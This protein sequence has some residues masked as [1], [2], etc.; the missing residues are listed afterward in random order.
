[1]RP[2]SWSHRDSSPFAASG[3]R[4]ASVRMRKLVKLGTMIMASRIPLHRSDTLKTRKY[5][6][7]KPITKQSSVARIEI[8]NV[9]SNTVK[10]VLSNAFR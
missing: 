6:T 8:R 1:M 4:H 9:V 3:I 7:G 2:M 10:K 5:D